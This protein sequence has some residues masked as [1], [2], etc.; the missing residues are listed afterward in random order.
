M[1]KDRFL[2]LKKKL[3]KTY[4]EIAFVVIVATTQKYSKKKGAF[5]LAKRKKEKKSFV[6]F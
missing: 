4:L 3:K 6:K 5:D 1:P 2:L